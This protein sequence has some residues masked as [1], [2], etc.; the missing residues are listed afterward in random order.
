MLP[1]TS[2]DLVFSVAPENEPNMPDRQGE[3]RPRPSYEET[4]SEGTLRSENT[5]DFGKGS[6][7]TYNDPTPSGE[8]QP[9][10]RSDNDDDDI[11]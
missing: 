3:A 7:S 1:V 5:P 11:R 8:P 6:L 2:T 4:D 9:S 10:R